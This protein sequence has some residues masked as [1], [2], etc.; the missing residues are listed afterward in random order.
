MN[1]KTYYDRTDNMSGLDL[2]HLLSFN[3]TDFSVQIYEKQNFC[4]I[5]VYKK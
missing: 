4:E 5:F 3:L 1:I 2:L